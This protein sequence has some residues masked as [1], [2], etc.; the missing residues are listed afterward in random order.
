M[1]DQPF[2]LFLDDINHVKHYRS[3]LAIER[4]A[5]FVVYGSDFEEGW[6]VA[7]HRIGPWS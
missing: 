4:S 7:G 6:M 3:K 1:G 5:D 2:L